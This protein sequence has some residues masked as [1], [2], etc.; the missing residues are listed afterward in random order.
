MPATTRAGIHPKTFQSYLRLQLPGMKVFNMPTDVPTVSARNTALQVAH[1]MGAKALLFIDSDM[2]FQSDAYQR[3]NKVKGDIVC[4]LFYT[5][6]AP[7]VPTIMVSQ[8]EDDGKNFSLR[9]IVPDGKVMDVDACGMAFTLIREPVMKWA[10][11]KSVKDGLP[12]FR[13]VVFGE[14][15]DFCMRARKAG[16][17]V[18]CD[19]SVKI[20][21]RGDVGFN[22]QPELVNPQSGYL[23]H[24]FGNSPS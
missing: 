4:G 17:S 11:E 14:D 13:H 10:I 20:A 1:E 15:L 16:F 19:T 7:S 6:S 3:L 23:N 8:A 18:K 22:G 9:T 2:E 12:P 24:P 5:R 21:H